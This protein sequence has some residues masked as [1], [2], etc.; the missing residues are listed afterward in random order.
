MQTLRAG[1]YGLKVT[2]PYREAENRYRTYIPMFER[3]VRA[4]S[5]SKPNMTCQENYWNQRFLIQ[6]LL[7]KLSSRPS[8]LK[9]ERLSEGN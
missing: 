6:Q 1:W 4:K 7:Y 3:K 9:V 2:S 8:D 5:K